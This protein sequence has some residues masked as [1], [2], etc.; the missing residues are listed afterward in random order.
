MRLLRNQKIRTKLI[1]AFAI[2]LVFSLVIS[3]IG[4]MGMTILNSSISDI[5]TGPAVGTYLTTLMRS[6]LNSMQ[7]QLYKGIMAVD[8]EDT[9]TADAIIP[10]LETHEKDFRLFCDQY[11]ESMFEGD[12]ENSQLFSNLTNGYEVV[13]A[14]VAVYKQA[15]ANGDRDGMRTALSEIQ[16]VLPGVMGPSSEI[17]DYNH[18]LMLEEDENTT[19]LVKTLTLVV[20]VAFVVAALLAVLLTYLISTAI[21]VP[22]R[23][24]AAA[25]KR[26]ALGDVDI[27]LDI[28]E[29]RDEIGELRQSF[30][31]M[32][33]GFQEQAHVLNAMAEGD[34]SVTL[35]ARSENDVVGLAIGKMLDN[36]NDVM[37]EIRQAAA[38]VASGSAQIASGASALATGSTQQA[39]TVEE[40]TASI[41]SIHAQAEDNTEL[42]SKTEKDSYEVGR[43]MGESMEHM[44]EMTDSMKTI[45][46]SSLEIAKVIEVIDDIAFQTN[47]LAL[48]AAVEAARAGEHGK[49]FA[50]VSDEVRNLAGK[51]A[52]AAKE[53]AALIQNSVDNV[54]AGVDT[55]AKNSESLAQVAAIATAVAEVMGQ[56]SLA[57]NQQSEALNEV[58]EAV[59]QI[60]QVVHANSA[61]AEQSA[62]AAQEMNAQ[63]ALLNNI[64]ARFRLRDMKGNQS[65]MQ[66]LPEF[67]N[68]DDGVVIA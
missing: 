16:L 10:A 35:Q 14:Q 27:Q 45:E 59:G 13:A 47:I 23:K 24:L 64:I 58:N 66:G 41:G 17:I 60:S 33:E 32:M 11:K 25:S 40:L 9:E 44:S 68:P 7:A 18:S 48:N 46:G 56:I 61:N 12:T 2:M 36:I 30:L 22:S 42:A 39:A 54:S 57:S 37:C 6:N 38:Q 53:T 5:V 4:F 43:L 26:M 63:S 49:G 52:D 8:E 29:R 51:S 55:A 19:A 67:H 21:A 1:L 20:V 34:Y 28:E 3:I 50:V 62:A 65:R 15:L 31:A